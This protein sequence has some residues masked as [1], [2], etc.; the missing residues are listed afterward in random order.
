MDRTDACTHPYPEGD[1]SVRRLA[2][3]AA[4]LGYDSIVAI[5]AAACPDAAVPVLT[6][7]LVRDTSVKGVMD[8][9]RAGSRQ[10]D[11]VI[12]NAGDS[13]F[14]RS[15]LGMRGV[16]VL[17]HLSRTSRNS[18][19]HVA[20]RLAAERTIAVDIDIHPLVAARGADRQRVIA[21]Y[22]DILRLMRRFGFPL[23]ISTNARSILDQRSVRDVAGLCALFGMDRGEVDAALA[24]VGR[25][26]ADRGPVRVVA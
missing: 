11:I 5:G 9:V 26:L 3:E 23:T 13:G 15:V 24:G 12:V 21:R 20:A 17:R 7:L 18:F 1:S 22:A 6:G 25:V 4:G 2:L 8:R 10:A 16:H 14:N 19:D